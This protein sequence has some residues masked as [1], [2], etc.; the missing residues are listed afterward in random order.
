MIVHGPA[1]RRHKSTQMDIG[2]DNLREL[3]GLSLG[4]AFRRF[5]VQH[6]SIFALRDEVV[7]EKSHLASVFTNAARPGPLTEY[8]WPI[9]ITADQ[10]AA[11]FLNKISYWARDPVV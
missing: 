6:P 5:V 3:D 10:L 4:A 8:K 7:Q 9:D 11:L 2:S 1:N